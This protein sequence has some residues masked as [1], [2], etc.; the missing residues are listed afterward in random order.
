LVILLRFFSFRPI[1]FETPFTLDVIY[2]IRS[3][4]EQS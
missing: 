4:Q 3:H 2:L 1:F